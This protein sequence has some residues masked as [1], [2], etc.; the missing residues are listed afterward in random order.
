ME[1][2]AAAGKLHQVPRNT[3]L[4]TSPSAAIH[5]ANI[6]NQQQQQVKHARKALLILDKRRSSDTVCHQSDKITSEKYMIPPPSGKVT[7]LNDCRRGTS[8]R[9]A[10]SYTDRPEN[11]G[12]S[13][14]QFKQGDSLYRVAQSQ[15]L[16]AAYL[17]QRRDQSLRFVEL[18][19]DVLSTTIYFFNKFAEEFSKTFNLCCE[20]LAE[21]SGPQRRRPQPRSLKLRCMCIEAAPSQPKQLSILT[22]QQR[23]LPGVSDSTASSECDRGRT[24]NTS[25]SSSSIGTGSLQAQEREGLCSL[26]TN[27][28]RF[29]DSSDAL[30][31]ALETLDG[32]EESLAQLFKPEMAEVLHQG[33]SV[34]LILQDKS[35]LDCKV[36]LTSDNKSLE[37]SCDRKSRVVELSSVKSILHTSEHL[38]RVDCSAGIS[39]GDFCVAIQLA[40][41]GNCIPLF[42]PSLRE[43]NLFVITLA[44]V[45]SPLHACTKHPLVIWLAGVEQ[46]RK[47]VIFDFAMPSACSAL[48]CI[49]ESEHSS[50]RTPK[51]ACGARVH[52]LNREVDAP[53][54]S[55]MFAF[56]P[57]KKF[58]E[59][60]ARISSDGKKCKAKKR[61][62]NP[63]G[64]F[65]SILVFR[66]TWMLTS[67]VIQRRKGRLLS[68]TSNLS[69]P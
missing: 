38:R 50:N 28:P 66:Q 35:R 55:K 34:G 60:H 13:R 69:N 41:T 52:V 40:A 18:V 9:Q 24:S 16:H 4:N 61:E 33:V 47:L 36:T 11:C 26:L 53:I 39:P 57:K 59:N 3:R 68:P 49:F 8:E 56:H 65:T 19:D 27:K 23:G 15:R 10:G 21:R 30:Q 25:T 51:F 31:M 46:A 48:V 45:R 6:G 17:F 20:R 1:C 67:V 7:R 37:L 64:A 29:H 2:R 42:F 58:Q 44:K 14:D 62:A 5:S 43:K 54:S 32:S 22:R 63:G 12:V